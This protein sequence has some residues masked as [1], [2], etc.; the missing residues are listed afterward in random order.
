MSKPSPTGLRR[1]LCNT[2]L[3]AG[4]AAFADGSA[5]AQDGGSIYY[6]SLQPQGPDYPASYG[7]QFPIQ[8]VAVSVK[9]DIECNGGGL[10]KT[11][12]ANGDAAPVG[13]GGTMRCG[14]AAEWATVTAEF[15][16]NAGTQVVHCEP[17]RLP[18]SELGDG[19]S[20]APNMVFIKSLD[21]FTKPNGQRRIEN[22]S[23]GLT[24]ASK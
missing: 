15:L 8:K 20:G 6:V 10:Y 4:L 17:T 23:A 14:D 18:L 16:M 22:C 12:H 9:L 1:A 19:Q 24:P 2:V 21:V 3:A 7:P 11:F 13:Y 5:V